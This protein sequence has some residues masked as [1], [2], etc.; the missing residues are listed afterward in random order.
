M[1]R[2]SMT[3]IIRKRKDQAEME[4]LEEMPFL[5]AHG[6]QEASGQEDPSAMVFLAVKPTPPVA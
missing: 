3:K 6:D 1:K 5:L 2:I 4:T